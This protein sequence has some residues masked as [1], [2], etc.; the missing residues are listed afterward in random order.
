MRGA[1]LEFVLG[2]ARL[3]LERELA[4]NKP[5]GYDVLA[6]ETVDSQ[7]LPDLTVLLY[8]PGQHSAATTAFYLFAKSWLTTYRAKA[9]EGSAAEEVSH[10]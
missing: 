2:D 5:Q 7:P 9:P 8:Q 1:K 10:A 6:V 3:S 4:Q